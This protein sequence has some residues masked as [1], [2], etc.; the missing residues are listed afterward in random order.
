MILGECFYRN[1]IATSVP[2]AR[3]YG[4]ADNLDEGDGISSPWG[5]VRAQEVTKS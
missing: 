3:K 1:G 5:E 2:A 4:D